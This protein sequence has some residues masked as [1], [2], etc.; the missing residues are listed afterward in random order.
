MSVVAQS[1]VST[2]VNS[3][4]TGTELARNIRAGF[5]TEPLKVVMA[6]ATVHH[7]PSALLN[8]LREIFGPDVRVIGCSSQGLIGRGIADERGYIAGAIGLGGSALNASTGCV[9]DFHVESVEKGR[10]LGRTLKEGAKAPLKIVLLHYDPLCGADLDGFLSGLHEVVGCPVVGGAAAE[11]WGPWRQTFQ[12]VDQRVLSKGAVAVGLSG[13]C[14]IETDLCHGTA[15][16]GVEMTVTKAE[17]NTLLELD[18]RP[19]LDVWQEICA[20]A[21]ANIPES[22]ALGVGLPTKDPAV[23]R[24][25][26]VVEADE[27]RLGVTFQCGLPTGTRVTFH[28]R[29][30]EGV[31]GGTQKMARNLNDRLAGKNI[32]AVLGYECGARC[33]PFL[34]HDATLRENVAL[35]AAL[36]PD[37]AWLGTIVWGEIYM[38]DGQPALAN[39]SYPLVVIAD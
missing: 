30:V 22:G 9:E 26:C 19:A 12:Y 2:S 36:S 17:G 16:I 33:S 35:Q 5:G 32:R 37:A 4:E 3:F 38:F 15:T 31:V 28:Q 34:G 1:H 8:G 39:F 21:P 25:L 7:D 11:F 29:T 20:A 23:Q 6:Y 27:K 18:G 24:V 14:T 10:A 13:D